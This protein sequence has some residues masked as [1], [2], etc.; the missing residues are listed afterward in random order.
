MEEEKPSWEKVEPIERVYVKYDPKSNLPTHEAI[1]PNQIEKEVTS[2][3]SAVCVTDK[4]NRNLTPS[5][6]ELLI[7]HF[8]LG[9]LGSNMCNG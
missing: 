1:I 8:R 4:A 5:N 6:K 9:Q 7:W 2:S 3:A